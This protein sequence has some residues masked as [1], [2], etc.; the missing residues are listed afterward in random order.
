MT[1]R[2]FFC[3]LLLLINALPLV[4]QKEYLLQAD[5]AFEIGHYQKAIRLYT[6]YGDINKDAVALGKRGIA[7]Y[8]YNLVDKAVEDFTA[9]KKLGNDNPILYLKM[10]QSKQF[11]RSFDEATFFYQKYLDLTDDK[12]KY[13]KLAE[14]EIK[15]CVFSALQSFET[16]GTLIQSFGDDINSRYDEIYPIQSPTFGNVFYFSSNR[17]KSNFDILSYTLSEDGLWSKNNISEKPFNN[18]SHNVALDVDGAEINALLYSE[19][20]M[21]GETIQFASFDLSGRDIVVQLPPEIFEGAKDISIVNHNMLVFASK[22]LPG[23]G[24]Y[25]IYTVTYKDKKW[26][27]PLNLGAAIN[28]PFDEICPFYSN[29]LN[30]FYFSSNRPYSFGG[31][32]IYYCDIGNKKNPVNMGFGIN[33]HGDDLH[34]NIDD[35][36]HMTTF[37][38]NRKTGLGGFDLYFGYLQDIKNIGIKDSLVF[39]Y[40]VNPSEEFVQLK[41]QDAITSL[42]KSS[43]ELNSNSDDSPI[44]ISNKIE[45]IKQRTQELVENDV[46]DDS[47]TS[48]DNSVHTNVNL[49]EENEGDKSHSKNVQNQNIDNSNDIADIQVSDKSESAIDKD[50]IVNANQNEEVKNK[51]TDE[52]LDGE[53]EDDL[54]ISD[55]IQLK[56]ENSIDEVDI[57][58]SDKKVDKV[59]QDIVTK[60]D[61]SEATNESNNNATS[62]SLKSETI[63][64]ATFD[65]AIVTEPK[66][67][68]VDKVDNENILTEKLSNQNDQVTKVENNVSEFGNIDLNKE[69]EIDVKE[70]TAS[71]KNNKEILIVGDNEESFNDKSSETKLDSNEQISDSDVNIDTQPND[72]VLDSIDP[73]QDQSRQ[74]EIMP[75]KLERKEKIGIDKERDFKKIKKSWATFSQ[76]QTLYYQD[77]Q[78]LTRGENLIKLN[79]LIIG[80]YESNS[81]V[82]ILAHTDDS[83]LGLPEY[84]QYN[85]FKRALKIAEYLNASGISSER[86]RIESLANN[87]PL[88][89]SEIA[90]KKIDSL[91]AHNKRIDILI[92]GNND[93]KEDNIINDGSI[94]DYAFDRKYELFRSIREGTYYSIEI[95]TTA[96]IFKN[97]VLRLY[98]DIYMR[99]ETLDDKNKY[100]IGIYTQKEDAEKVSEQLSKTSTPYAKVVKFVNGQKTIE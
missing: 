7:N 39:E 55:N 78:D 1:G 4:S 82:I 16:A 9:A 58:T 90:G 68:K 62:K 93:V 29:N 44:E 8:N 5:Q 35:A 81:S 57:Q 72:K 27:T 85:T 83:E 95:A 80:E 17:N 32:D 31:H 67:S 47:V 30:H 28:S 3:Y 15:N 40:L 52:I 96:R 75:S 86:I 37:S 74:K 22:K 38:S 41:N 36:G 98:N 21:A 26:S 84:V 70:D 51:K 48:F 92:R 2:I 19:V 87:F 18:G 50:I 45:P 14:L 60:T 100:Y 33:S 88:I 24:G 63:G 49:Q 64:T 34:F 65:T 53:F 54:E 43:S 69:L 20:D 91:Y 61:H 6:Q 11:Q 97:A 59:T 23:F 73:K 66:T 71:D 10:G 56:K 13:R 77:R 79:Q 99:R 89:K 25:D 42:E 76:P 94:P 12:A 46:L